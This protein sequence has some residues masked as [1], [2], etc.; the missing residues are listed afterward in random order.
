M[1]NLLHIAKRRCLEEFSECKW[2]FHNF[3]YLT[4]HNTHNTL[5]IIV[6][7]L[8]TGSSPYLRVNLE[9]SLLNKLVVARVLA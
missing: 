8:F 4:L 1:D 3:K 7:C 6:S 5:N 2:N 9:V